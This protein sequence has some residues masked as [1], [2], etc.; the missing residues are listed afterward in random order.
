MNEWIRSE[1]LK[2]KTAEDGG[3]VRS[4]SD[5]AVGVRLA[6]YRILLVHAMGPE[7][8]EAPSAGP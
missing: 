2:D 3:L 8:G 5:M 4:R 1:D 6:L 7:E